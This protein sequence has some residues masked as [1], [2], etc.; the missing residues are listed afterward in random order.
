MAVA[1]AVPRVVALPADERAHAQAEAIVATIEARILASSSATATLADWCRAQGLAADP[2]ITAEWDNKVQVAPSPDQ[3]ARLGIGPDDPVAYRRVRLV[4][5]SLVL[6]VAENWYVPG[7]L[8][9]AMVQTLLTTNTPFGKVIE[10]LRPERRT[11]A[12]ERLWHPVP[13]VRDGVASTGAAPCEV[14]PDALFRHQVLVLDGNG[15]PLAEVIETYQRDL[16]AF[17]VPWAARSIR[18]CRD[19]NGASGPE[20]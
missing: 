9:P 5:G 7:R 2:T 8:D 3:R 4:C 17:G 16:I 14:I 18:Q 15:R 1:L 11:I 10:P 20:R 13:V 19:A 12:N 6:S